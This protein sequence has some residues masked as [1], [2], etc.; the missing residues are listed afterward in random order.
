MVER[1]DYLKDLGVNAVELL[2]VQVWES[3]GGGQGWVRPRLD[4]CEISGAAVGEGLILTNIHT[5]TTFSTPVTPPPSPSLPPPQEF[6]ELEYYA[7]IPGS[8]SYRHN[9][10]GYSTVGF[11]APMSRCGGPS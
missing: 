9:F 4:R 5:F 3:V 1:L 8:H 10:W 2:P 7:Q 6:N 11:F